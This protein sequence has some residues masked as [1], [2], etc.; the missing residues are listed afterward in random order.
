MKNVQYEIENYLKSLNSDEQVKLYN[1][2]FEDC[3]QPMD[4]LEEEFGNMYLPDFLTSFD[5]SDSNFRKNYYTVDGQYI[6][7]FDHI[8]DEDCPFNLEELTQFILESG[9][10]LGD[11]NIKKILESEVK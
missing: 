6:I 9:N 8:D 10:F 5:I 11:E 4:E 7:T 1:I 3:I 2:A